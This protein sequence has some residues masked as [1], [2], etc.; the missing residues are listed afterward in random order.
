MVEHM[1]N[2][3][4]AESNWEE[5]SSGHLIIIPVSI[6]HPS[7]AL[8]RNLNFYSK[9]LQVSGFHPWFLWEHVTKA[10]SIYAF[11]ALSCR[12]LFKEA[13]GFDPVRECR[14]QVEILEQ[15]CFLSLDDGMVWSRWGVWLQQPPF[16][17]GWR[18]E[19]E[20]AGWRPRN[21]AGTMITRWISAPLDFTV[22]WSNDTLFKLGT[23]DIW[24]LGNSLLW[25]MCCAS[26]D[27]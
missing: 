13:C 15:R 27:V 26:Q 14:T 11:H 1:L 21:G 17:W 8:P 18:G 2:G 16:I 6:T 12:D 10:K 7:T 19:E 25:G 3:Q 4:K 20:E 22:I 9:W 24:W 5:K 23:L